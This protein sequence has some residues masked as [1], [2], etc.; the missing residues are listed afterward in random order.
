M[1]SIRSQIFG[2]FFIPLLFLPTSGKAETVVLNPMDFKLVVASPAVPGEPLTVYEYQLV[3][4]PAPIYRAVGVTLYSLVPP[5]IDDSGFHGVAPPR[6]PHPGG[7]AYTAVGIDAGSNGVLFDVT[8]TTNAADVFCFSDGDIPRIEGGPGTYTFKNVASSARCSNFTDVPADFAL[9][10]FVINFG[11]APSPTPSPSPSPSPSPTVV[12]YALKV[13]FLDTPT[14]IGTDGIITA[15]ILPSIEGCGALSQVISQRNFVVQCIEKAT[16]NVVSGCKVKAAIAYGADHGGHDHDFDTRP[17]GSLTPD[18]ITV[19]SI[20][21][22]ASGLPMTYE[23]PEISG[24]VNLTLSGFDSNGKGITGTGIQF[25]VTRGD[26][27]ALRAPGFQISVDSHPDG[28][29]GTDKMQ[30]ALEKLINLFTARAAKIHASLTIQSQGGSL[31]HGGLFDYDYAH[32]H[33]WTTPHC[34]HRDGETLDLSYSMF[35]AYGPAE[36]VYLIAVLEQSIK[37]A[38]MTFKYEVG[39]GVDGKH[40]HLHL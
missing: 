18:N 4:S 23:S 27:S 1:R 22:P 5:T 20:D 25:Q 8:F 29:R 36:K 13:S 7:F 9:S 33:V 24:D 14:P 30:A 2:L 34:G 37:D 26:F 10:S 17:L 28:D 16:G 21:I 15:K 35:D 40:W 39:D 6:F 12:P 31:P 19:G 38:K 3:L 11:P 32:G